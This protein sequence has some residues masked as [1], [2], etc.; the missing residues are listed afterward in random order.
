MCCFQY[1]IAAWNWCLMCFFDIKDQL[2]FLKILIALLYR[3]KIQNTFAVY[4]H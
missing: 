1:C 4:G 2:P 3:K